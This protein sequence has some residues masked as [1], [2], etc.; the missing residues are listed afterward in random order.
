MPS[1]KKPR[2]LFEVPVELG[3]GLKSG[4]VYRSSTSAA[5]TPRAIRENTTTGVGAESANT[6]ALAIATLAQ[7]FVLVASIAAIPVTIGM[8][9]LQSLSKPNESQ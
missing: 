2:P 4:W 1:N 3:S 8:R 7:T 6:L 5:E 9:A